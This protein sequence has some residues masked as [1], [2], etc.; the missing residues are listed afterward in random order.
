MKALT[1]GGACREVPTWQQMCNKI[2][3]SPREHESSLSS[4]F[5]HPI[6]SYSIYTAGS[7]QKLPT[8]IF[9]VGITAME[10]GSKGREVSSEVTIA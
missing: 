6:I 1:S 9:S 7:R 5:E 2:A 8:G 3:T 10:R 4:S